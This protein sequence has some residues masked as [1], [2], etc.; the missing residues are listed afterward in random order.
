MVPGSTGQRVPAGKG[1]TP[2]T[3][4]TVELPSGSYRSRL[5]PGT[6]R[7][8]PTS[9]ATV[10]NNVAAVAR[11]AT[12]VAT[13]RSAACSSTSTRRLSR[14]SLFTIEVATRSVKP[15]TRAS[16]SAGSASGDREPSVRTPQTLPSTTIG[17]PTAER[18]GLE[19]MA[20]AIAPV[21]SE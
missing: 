15:A 13:R 2:H 19:R 18:H 6:P 8:R 16:M 7:T 12:S 10:E 4:S 5:T 14:A 9:S 3:A 21:S 20:A 1:A 11:S 17:T